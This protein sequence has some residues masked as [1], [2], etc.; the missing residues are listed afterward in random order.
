VANAKTTDI[1]YFYVYGSE[2]TEFRYVKCIKLIRDL[3]E[4]WDSILRVLIF[5]VKPPPNTDHDC[6][7]TI[8]LKCNLLH[9]ENKLQQC[10]SITIYAV[11]E[12]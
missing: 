6:G 4:R 9:Q 5:R 2:A 11:R 1:L 7:K 3:L 8:K 10:V 12:T